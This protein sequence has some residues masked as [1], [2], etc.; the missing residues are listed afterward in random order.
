MK[1]NILAAMAAACMIAL[2]LGSAQAGTNWVYANGYAKDH[3]QT[4]IL[5]DEFIALVKEKTKG[6]LTIRHVAGGALLKSENMLD[7][8]RGG[9]SNMGSAVI[10]F[11]PGQLPISATLSGLVDAGI[12]SKLS[13]S[14]VSNITTK[15][16]QEMPEINAEYEKLG[17]KPLWFVPTPPYAVISN[18]PI[19]KL[20]DFKG[21]KV[22]T[23][24]N[25]LPKLIE[26]MGGVPV[27]VAFAEIYTSLQTGVIN[28]A[29]TD[30]PAMRNAKFQEV[31]KNLVI[32]GP[33]LGTMTAMSPV[34]FIVNLDSWKA[35]P[36][37]VQK[38]VEAAAAEMTARAAE[39]MTTYANDTLKAL[40]EEGVTI[41]H[42][43]IE[44][45]Q[46]V[47]AKAP[48]VT[49]TLPG[50]LKPYGLDGDAIAKKYETIVNTYLAGK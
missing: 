1:S 44:E 26:A 12:G 11:S 22:R 14:D 35:L 27:S 15:L 10:S 3:P 6:E 5:A 46:E 31:S 21:K 49:G 37:E 48:S 38:E 36:P 4:G 17:L 7:G 45:M 30:P 16:L 20:A 2:G 43:T 39:R 18:D 33:D 23:F 24:G 28:G 32:F 9:I 13:L 19:A 40:A 34:G 8:V 50:I 25:I 42:L 41:N 29:L 47:A